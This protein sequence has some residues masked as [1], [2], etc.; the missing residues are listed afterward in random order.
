MLSATSVMLNAAVPFRVSWDRE[1]PRLWQ[2]THRNTH[3]HAQIKLHNHNYG[4]K[5][6]NVVQ[7]HITRPNRPAE[8]CSLMAHFTST[9]TILQFFYNCKQQIKNWAA[10]NQLIFSVFSAHTYIIPVSYT[11]R[12]TIQRVGW[13]ML[14]RG[15]PFLTWI[16]FSV[17]FWY[18]NKACSLKIHKKRFM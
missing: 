6:Y 16:C 7:R 13:G 15:I 2:F 3:S 11:L 5:P 14:F 18:Q 17:I 12:N 4:I 9:S 1:W 10:H 8:W